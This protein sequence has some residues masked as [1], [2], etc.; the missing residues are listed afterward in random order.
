MKI[1]PK[2]GQQYPET[3]G[4]CETDG[5]VLIEAGGSLRGR[6]TTVMTDE[7]DT[8]RSLECP[9][10]GGKSLPGEVH[11]NYCGARL[12]VEDGETE[13]PTPQFQEGAP[14]SLGSINN[15]PGPR[16]FGEEPVYGAEAEPPKK[17]R[18]VV[19]ILGFTS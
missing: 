2:C 3:E 15:A 7:A 6:L 10:C 14:G 5:S 13:Q 17:G 18:R 19:A 11:C 1:C 9:V 4:F 16:E 12:R 8:E